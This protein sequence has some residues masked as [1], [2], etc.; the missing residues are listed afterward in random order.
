MAATPEQHAERVEAVRSEL[1]H[2]DLDI[3]RSA[4][5][6]VMASLREI[7]DYVT[8]DGAGR[9]NMVLAGGATAIRFTREGEIRGDA[10]TGIHSRISDP[11]G[12]AAAIAALDDM[13][14]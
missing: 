7:I 9:I 4:R 6:K 12:Q 10:S 5:Q 2:E 8:F 14:G 1:E 3:R 11:K 13:F